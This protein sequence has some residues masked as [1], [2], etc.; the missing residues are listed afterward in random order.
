[1][2]VY[3]QVVKFAQQIKNDN[4][5]NKIIYVKD[6]NVYLINKNEL[7]SQYYQK[8][9]ILIVDDPER[10]LREINKEPT[11]QELNQFKFVGEIIPLI[12]QEEVYMPNE[13]WEITIMNKPIKEILEL[14]TLSKEWRDRIDSLW[15][16]LIERDF[17]TKDYNKNDCYNEYKFMYGYKNMPSISINEIRDKITTLKLKNVTI[18]DII[19]YFEEVGFKRIGNILY[20]DPNIVFTDSQFL[21]WLE[22]AQTSF[23]VQTGPW[24]TF[25]GKTK[26]KSKF[27]ELA[28]FI[29][30][31]TLKPFH[32]DTYPLSIT[33]K[34]LYNLYEKKYG[35]G[36]FEKIYYETFKNKYKSKQT[37]KNKLEL[38]YERVSMNK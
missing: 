17:K 14:R 31:I 23:S 27:D 25:F 34:D 6:K 2:S 7:P 9:N 8:T 3:N 28:K 4:I 35:K 20:F 19:L 12:E 26:W 38:F 10:Y 36:A 13:L 32:T 29:K 24:F 15:C 30:N 21:N 16:K 11:Q 37:I 18:N 33:Y 5:K 22:G 1:M